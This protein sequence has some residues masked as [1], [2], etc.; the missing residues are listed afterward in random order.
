MTD[1]FQVHCRV[2]QMHIVKLLNFK[3]GDL[4]LLTATRFYAGI[5]KVTHICRLH[6]LIGF[7]LKHATFSNPFQSFLPPTLQTL[8]SAYRGRCTFQC[9]G[10]G[11]KS[12]LRPGRRQQSHS[13]T[14]GYKT[15]CSAKEVTTLASHF[16]A[17]SRASSNGL[18]HLG[19]AGQT[20]QT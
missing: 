7:L 12:H 5:G 18:V 15:W 13:K 14:C 6:L 1:I 8:Q 16:L 20:R 19:P 10:L 17:I 4:I 11:Q 9:V 3:L 2:L